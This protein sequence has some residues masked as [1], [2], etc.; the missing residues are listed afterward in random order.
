MTKPFS[1]RELGARIRAIF[2]RTRPGIEGHRSRQVLEHRGLVI[3]VDRHSVTLDGRPI[4][5]TTFQ[6]DLLRV[7]VQEPGRVFSRKELLEATSGSVYEGYERTMDVHVKN[8]RK[9]LEVDPTHPSR[10]VTV[11][12]VGYKIQEFP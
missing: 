11:W 1:V 4:P 2:R 8:I 10:L 3:D 6:F 9:V 7:L 12:G 5:L